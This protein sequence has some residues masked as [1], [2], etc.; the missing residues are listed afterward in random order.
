MSSWWPWSTMTYEEAL[1]KALK[2]NHLWGYHGGDAYQS[3][4]Y[5][6]VVNEV[7]KAYMM[8]PLQGGKKKRSKRRSATKKSPRRSRRY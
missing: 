3:A 5:V 8:P 7:R 4:K 2:D 1:Q 6:R